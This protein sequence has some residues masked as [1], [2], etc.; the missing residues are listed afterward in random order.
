MLYRLPVRAGKAGLKILHYI[1]ADKSDQRGEDMEVEV[2]RDTTEHSCR[3]EHSHEKIGQDSL[4]SPA[5][6]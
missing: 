2:S 1:S 5:D 3:K 4:A 6:L